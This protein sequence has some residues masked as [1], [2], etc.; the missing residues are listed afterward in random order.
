MIPFLNL[1]GRI[2]RLFGANVS[3]SEV[4]SGICLGMFLGFIPLNGPMAI[5]LFLC[6]FLFK[7]NRLAAMLILPLF[8][9]LYILGVSVLTDWLG[10]QIL[11]NAQFLAGF[12]GWVTHLPILAYLDLGNTLVVGGILLCAI[13][14]LPVYLVSKK[15]IIIIRERYFDR[16]KN[17]KFVAWLKKMPLLNKITTFV[18]RVRSRV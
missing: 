9:L 14:C 7:I 18:V 4:A 5:I 10:G 1:P 3:V 15:A 11:I 13:L 2:V 17:S 16:I 8:K 6:F 12:W